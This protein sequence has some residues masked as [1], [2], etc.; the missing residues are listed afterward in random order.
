MIAYQLVK[1]LPH[2]VQTVCAGIEHGLGRVEG[3]AGF[4][5]PSEGVGIEAN[6]CAHLTEGVLFHSSREITAVNQLKSVDF[7]GLLGCSGL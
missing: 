2:T 7:A 3:F 5:C 1:A 4:Q 6:L